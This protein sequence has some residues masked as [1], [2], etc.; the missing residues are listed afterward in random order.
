MPRTVTPARPRRRGRPSPGRPRKFEPGDRVQ[1][2]TGVYRELVNIETSG[3]PDRPIRFEA[4]PAAHVVVTGADEI[5]HRALARQPGPD[6][7]QIYAVAWT[8]HWGTHPNNEDGGI[9]YEISYGLHAHDNVFLGNGFDSLAGSWGGN[10][11]IGLSSSPGC[12]IERNLMLGNREGFQFREQQR[13]TPRIGQSRKAAEEPVWNHHETIRNNL[14]AYNEKWQIGGW[15]DVPDHR[16]L[17]ASLRCRWQAEDAA[18]AAAKAPGKHSHGQPTNL[19]LETLN[20]KFEHNVY[21][22]DPS[23]GLVLWGATW[24][25]GHRQYTAL[26]PWQA[27]LKIDEGSIETSVIFADPTKLDLRLPADSPAIRMG[28]Y[29]KGEVPGVVLGIYRPEPR[30]LNPAP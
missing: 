27:E 5:D 23:E 2:A 19:S 13:T 17:P 26:G 30:T 15:F 8:H 3:L 16:Y 22:R 11:A 10:G 28:C 1:I 20:I 7:D 29:P 6:G 14:I 24:D 4:A 12:T 9:F 18:R 25:R 21:A